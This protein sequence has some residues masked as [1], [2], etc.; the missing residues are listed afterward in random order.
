MS[1]LTLDFLQPIGKVQKG[2]ISSTFLV[3]CKH[4]AAII[5]HA[6]PHKAATKAQLIRIVVLIRK[7]SGQIIR[8]D[9]WGN[10]FFFPMEKRCTYNWRSLS[11]ESRNLVAPSMCFLN[12]SC[13]SGSNFG[14]SN[15][16][17]LFMKVTNC[18]LS[19]AGCSCE[20]RKQ[21]FQTTS[22]GKL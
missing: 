14:V 9:A 4:Q 6:L 7:V 16:I 3:V 10:N 8:I 18:F 15:L 2:W 19:K 21:L 17:Y 12:N 11:F 22:R 1:Q 20:F 13:F 5:M